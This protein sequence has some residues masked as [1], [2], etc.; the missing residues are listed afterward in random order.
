MTISRGHTDREALIAFYQ[1]T[2]G[3]HWWQ[4]TNWLSGAPLSRWFGVSVDDDGRVTE[5]SFVSNRLRGYIP[6]EIG[7]L[8]KLERLIL[9]NNGLGKPATILENFRVSVLHLFLGAT[10][11]EKGELT[12][13]LGSPLHPKNAGP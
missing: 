6:P 11:R 13:A 2:D 3:Q 7:D 10:Y 5:L 8:A 12:Q 9:S 1:V 4:S